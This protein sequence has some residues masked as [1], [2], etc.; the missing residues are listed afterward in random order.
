MGRDWS[1]G[2][3]WLQKPGFFALACP[4]LYGLREPHSDCVLHTIP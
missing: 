3:G 1:R 2:I 4:I